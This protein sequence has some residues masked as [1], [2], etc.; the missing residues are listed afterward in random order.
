MILKS[1]NSRLSVV[2]LFTD[3]ILNKIPKEEES[4]IQIVDCLNFYVIKGKTTYNEPLDIS[5]IKDEFISKYE[6]ILGDIIIHIAFP[7]FS[8]KFLT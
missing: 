8:T 4:I 5:S 6:S 7:P 2:N 1:P 3:F